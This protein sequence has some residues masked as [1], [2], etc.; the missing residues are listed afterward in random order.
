M[1]KKI[2]HPLELHTSESR[3]K[4]FNATH[5]KQGYDFFCL[6]TSTRGSIYRAPTAVASWK[7]PLFSKYF[8]C[9]H[10]REG[11]GRGFPKLRSKQQRYRRINLALF[12]SPCLL[13]TFI[14]LT[15]LIWRDFI[16]YASFSTPD[17]LVCKMYGKLRSSWN[18]VWLVLNCIAPIYARISCENWEIMT[19]VA[20]VL[21]KNNFRNMPQRLL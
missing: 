21:C 9:F 14:S 4:K 11:K 5:N 12:T 20:C 17:P 3:G 13:A 2:L 19:Y 6:R 10:A 16:M 15:V 18:V 7:H 8:A 1:Q